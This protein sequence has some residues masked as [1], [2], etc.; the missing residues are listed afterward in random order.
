[1]LGTI[2]T[3]VA[4]I[5]VSTVGLM[6]LGGRI[7]V[8]HG[9]TVIVGCFILFGAPTIAAGIQSFIGGGDAQARPYQ[10][11]PPAPV[12]PPL[13][14]RVVRSDPYAGASVPNR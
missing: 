5:A 9:V 14:P 12:P 6:M 1:M 8:R 10:P 2:A 11:E 13:P 3:I 7:N 4:V